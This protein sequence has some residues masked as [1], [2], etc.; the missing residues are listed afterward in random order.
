MGK[1]SISDL[2]KLSGI[3]SHTLRMWEKRYDLLKTKRTDTNIRFYDDDDLRYMLNVSLLVNNG[4]KI[5]KVAAMSR[6]EINARISELKGQATA[7]DYE[8]STLIISMT[9]MDEVKFEKIVS[10]SMLRHGIEKTVINILYPFLN[11]IGIMWQTGSINPA[12]EHFISNLIRQKLLVA[13]D[14][15]VVPDLRLTKRF[16]L[17]L[18]EDELHEIGLLFANYLIRAR[19][20]HTLYLGQTVPTSDIIETNKFY[21][22]DFIF[23]IITS[24]FRENEL[25]NYLKEIS[26]LFPET[27]ILVS[28]LAIDELNSPDLPSNVTVLKNV[29]ATIA[30]LDQNRAANHN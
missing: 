19:G 5:S 2:E 18:P 30:F 7:F 26:S 22:A 11:K 8:I 9:E 12:Q 13:T 27:R 21:K 10:S 15:L 24:A 20:N 1:Y 16:L 25:V 14:G 4:V 17:F 23:T 28:G 6:E 29:D 3:K